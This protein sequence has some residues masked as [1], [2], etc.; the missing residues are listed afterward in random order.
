MARKRIQKP[1]TRK[2]DS[3]EDAEPG[4]YCYYLST[5]NRPV[6]A[7]ITEVREENGIKLLHLIC[8]VDFKFMNLPATICAFDE[9]LLKGKKRRD[10]CPEVYK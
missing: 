6:F 8:Q 3:I 7:E 10:L 4:D 2:E 9:K 1:E 5:S